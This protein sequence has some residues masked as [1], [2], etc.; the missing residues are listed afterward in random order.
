M[1]QK[2]FITIIL[3]LGF[4]NLN[5]QKNNNSTLH[6]KALNSRSDT[7]DIL[8]YQIN[9]DVTDFTNK[10]I[11]GNCVISYYSKLNGINTIGLD[12]LK[13]NIDSITSQGSV[14]SYSYNDT[15]LAVNLPSTLNVSDT[16]ELTVYY[17]GS[18][19]QD[20]SGWG[21]FYFDNTYAY[22]LGVGFDANPHN[23]GR[24]WFPCFDNFV[25]RSTYEF[26]ITTSNGKKAH[27]NGALISE[28]IITGDTIT[29]KWQMDDEIPTYLT[30]MAVSDYETVN[31][32]FNGVNGV[33]P[34]ELVG[35]VSDTTNMKNSFINLNGALNGYEQSYGPFLWNKIGYS[36]VPFSSGAMEHA[37]NIAYPRLAANG[38]LGNETLMAHEFSHHW[39]GDLVTCET[40]EDMW[41]NEGMAVYSEHLFLEKIYDYQT[42]LTE[43]KN[44]HKSVL[45]YTHINEGGFRAISG[46]PHE[47]TYGE[48]VYQK[49]ASV[50]HNMRAY[51][52]DSLFFMGLKSVLNTYKFNS[53]NSSQFRDELTSSTGINMTNFFNDWV[54]APGF[55]HFDIDSVD[56]VPN[57]PNFDITIDVQQ[58]LRGATIFHTGT[59][60]EITF[61]DDNWNMY[62]DT[63]IASS[64]YSTSNV[65]IPFSPTVYILNES[66]RLNQART[67]NQLKLTAT[68]SSGTL[69]LS[70]VNNFAVNSIGDSALLQFEHHWVAPDSIKNNINNYRISTSRYWSIDGILPPNLITSFRFNFDGR[71]SSGFLDVDLVP[72]NGDSIILLYRENP[73]F[74]WTEYPYYV[75]TTVGPTIAFGFVT[76]DSL[77]LGE[78]T[79][80]NAAP[81]LGIND[82]ISNNKNDF[83]I[84]PNPADDH[85]W[86]KNETSNMASTVMIY[87]LEGKLIHK[88][89]FKKKTKINTKKWRSGT[90][91]I[92]VSNVNNLPYTDKIIIH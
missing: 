14:L 36:L 19:Q 35:R 71:A 45:Q 5:A 48:H 86:V 23:F 53:I 55:S 27:C 43:I 52:G 65:T 49:G 90:Y 68:G 69:P 62:K 51:L 59:P 72:I 3:G 44:N 20:P 60:L 83:N 24:V 79:F 77:L 88:E 66:N 74:D 7:I 29:R 64:Q 89:I 6:N 1:V 57:G 25:E 41:I 75:K 32:S 13:L 10:L 87:N 70:L 30:C 37:T 21:G 15:L 63:I 12:L 84:Y 78:Y 67:D 82:K 9:L 39:W 61:Y 17:N 56:I 40:A 91:L 11:K 4:T 26:N 42:S 54:F 50:A 33:I 58:K 81:P 8:N 47:Y 34:V 2:I 73:K 16:S 46:I 85:I 22:N 18:P 31:M 76:L 80:A 92:T 38:T 28:I